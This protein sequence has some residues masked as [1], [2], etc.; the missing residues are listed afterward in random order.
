MSS[1]L[2]GERSWFTVTLDG[3][4]KR[5]FCAHPSFCPPIRWVWPRANPV[6]AY[7]R[8]SP[9]LCHMTCHQKAS[10]S[11]D[12][13]LFFDWLGQVHC[14]LSNIFPDAKQTRTIW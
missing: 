12:G 10:I 8:L 5:I 1:T 2:L 3:P 14:A 4:S 13:D 11:H 6:R 7:Q 9:T